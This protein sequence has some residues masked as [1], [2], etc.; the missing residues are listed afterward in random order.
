MT[1]EIESQ[2]LTGAA[3]GAAVG[4]TT[5]VVVAAVVVAAFVGA[6]T[7][8]VVVVGEVVVVVGAFVVVGAGVAAVVVVVG[9]VVVVAGAFVGG[10]HGVNMRF[11]VSPP[12]PF[13][14]HFLSTISIRFGV[15]GSFCIKLA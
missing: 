6:T 14:V 1:C 13:A 3:V 12:A 2:P 9:C 10:E 5:E 15:A 11:T 4:A 8:V 7:E